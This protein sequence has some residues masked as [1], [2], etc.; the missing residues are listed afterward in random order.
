MPSI[1]I[2]REVY[3]ALQARGRTF[4]DTPNSVLR[5]E[6][7][8][9]SDVRSRPRSKPQGGSDQRAPTGSILPE[10]E[11]EMPILRALVEAGGSASAKD[12]TDRVGELLASKLTAVDHELHHDGDVRWRNRTAFARLRLVRRGWLQSPSDWGMWAITPAGRKALEEYEEKE[13]A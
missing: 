11:Y 6:L 3:A 13:R 9:G 2:D 7:G 12:A 10:R 4:E 1:E 8:L 5:R